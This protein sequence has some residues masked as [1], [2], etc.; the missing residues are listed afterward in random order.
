[1]RKEG[2]EE[3]RGVPGVGGKEVESRCA[4]S[5]FPSE[6]WDTSEGWEEVGVD[7]NASQEDLLVEV[8]IVVVQQDGRVVHRGES[9]GW[10]TNLP[11]EATVGGGWE[12]LTLHR[13]VPLSTGVAESTPPGI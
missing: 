4:V 5:G 10:V 3:E 8:L 2:G 6:G 1:M 11:D 12:D 7:V 13:H 9:N